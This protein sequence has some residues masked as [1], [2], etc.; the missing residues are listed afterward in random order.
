MKDY[1]LQVDGLNFDLSAIEAKLPKADPNRGVRFVKDILR[2][3]TWKVGTGRS[4]VVTQDTLASI[5]KE[6]DRYKAN[7]CASPFAWGKP[8][9]HSAG[10]HDI[11]SRDTICDID[12]LIVVGDTL[13]A[14]GHTDK[15][16]FETIAKKRLKVSV[17]IK[18][19]WPDGNGNKYNGLLHHVAFVVHPVVSGQMPAVN[20]AVESSG[21]I[22]L[23]NQL[24]ELLGLPGVGE[25]VPEENVAG[26]VQAQIDTL[27]K[28]TGMD[29][30][31][32]ED[33]LAIKGTIEAAVAPLKTAVEA[34]EAKVKA[35]TDK[36]AAVEQA[37]Q[38]KQ[39]AEAKASFELAVKTA[40]EAEAIDA[41]QKDAL[42]AA[43]EAAGWSDKLLS[44]LPKTPSD[45][46]K[47]KVLAPEGDGKGKVKTVK[48]TIG[49]VEIALAVPT[50]EQYLAEMKDFGVDVS[51]IAASI[52]VKQGV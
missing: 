9:N 6:Y 2:V 27:K 32:D 16:T 19:E 20:L 44:I 14:V 1:N 33:L 21:M 7:G 47:K 22:G 41:G 49:G 17:G 42:L 40:F 10:Q 45:G 3:G 26:V 36:L 29:D 39:K 23:I 24:L 48:H 13:F 28:M 52:P 15:D 30:M 4:W 37:A 38:E 43:G 34:S 8:V 25:D 5:K 12:D 31:K 46:D 50:R 51:D 35:L 11:E 18:G